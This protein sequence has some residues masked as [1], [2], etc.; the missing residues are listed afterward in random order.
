M[1]SENK[2]SYFKD[3]IY[4]E[5]NKFIEI[6]DDTYKDIII[7]KNDNTDLLNYNNLRK[8]IIL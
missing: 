5:L 2:I 4:N 7:K 1:K 3:S 8:N 6:V